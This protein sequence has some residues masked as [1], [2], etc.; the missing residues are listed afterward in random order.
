[1]EEGTYDVMIVAGDEPYRLS[2]SLF[3]LARDVGIP[4]PQFYGRQMY[5][6]DNY[7]EKWLITTIIQGRIGD[8]DDPGVCYTQAFPDWDTS[9]EMAIHGAMSR[10]IFRYRDHVPRS[11]CFRFLGERD[12]DGCVADSNDEHDTQ[13]RAHLMEREAL[14]VATESL[15]QRQVAVIDAQRE[16]IQRMGVA[17]HNMDY[18]IESSKVREV[19]LNAAI[20]AIQAQSAFY[21]GRSY[22]VDKVKDENQALRVE[23]EELHKKMAQMTMIQEKPQEEPELI[24]EDQVEDA[25]E[26]EDLEEREPWSTSEEKSIPEKDLPLKKRK[27]TSEFYA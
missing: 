26:E 12:E 21:A 1:M 27:K 10:I 16:K 7:A 18:I 8:D 3:R 9:V 20:F 2:G 17:M 11:G 15:L 24:P 22:E 5:Y 25:E 6:D 4:P 23:I 13:I 14:A 19:K